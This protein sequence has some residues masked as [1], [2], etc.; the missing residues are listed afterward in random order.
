MSVATRPESDIDL[1]TEEALLDPYP[2]YTELRA[3]GPAVWL[4][5]LG[6]YALPR[7]ADVRAAGRNW[8][9]FSSQRGVM[10]N[11]E[12]NEMVGGGVTLCVDPPE[13][14]TMRQVLRRPLTG[15]RLTEIAPRLR[16][17]AERLVGRLVEQRT[18]DA[19][20]DMA[21]HLPLRVVSNLV[22]IPEEGREKMLE[23]AFASFDAQGPMSPR[24]AASG[25]IASQ[26]IAYS[27]N[28]AVPPKLRPGGWAQQ[29]YDAA[30]RG[31]IPAERC[32]MMLL[33]YLGPS[34]DTTIN[35]TSSAIWLF[36]EH[37]D[38]WDAVRREP[39]LIP[40]AINEVL[41]LESPVQHFSRYVNEDVDI[42]GVPVA[43]GSRV[44]FLYGSANRDER[45]WED[46]ETFDVRRARVA[47]HV[48]F[49]FGPHACVG[50]SLARL[51]LRTLLEALVE[52]VNRFEV[53]R[54]E[55]V[56]NQVLRGLTTLEVAVT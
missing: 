50:A 37:P 42:D 47:E 15:D 35:A 10:L 26:M 24:T 40:N 6:V 23:W 49:G 52:R 38:Q 29:L 56:T 32:P 3:A 8:E 43:A 11:E 17:E 33:D 19:V 53:R 55:R 54:T 4:N 39:S 45:R 30:A 48:A 16:T 12:L 51:E 41:R 46:P 14:D 34:L 1:F 36:A 22:G 27:L 9:V 5:R 25:E 31:E 2:L 7:Y 20:A 21:R 28:E 44:T 13:H 18:F